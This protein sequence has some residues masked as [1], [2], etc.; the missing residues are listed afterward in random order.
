MRDLLSAEITAQAERRPDA[1]ALVLAEERLTYGELEEQSN[2]LARLLL[3]VGCGR[4]DRVCLFMP[5]GPAV[6]IALLGVLKADAIWVPLD[7]VSPAAR[8]Q[9]VIASCDCRWILAAG[10]GVGALD[11]LFADADFAAAHD[12]GWLSATG[13]Q[14]QRVQPAFTWEDLAAYSPAPRVSESGSD[15]TAHILFTSGSTGVPKGVVITHRNALQFVRWARR[16]FG[17]GPDDRVSWHPPLHFD[18]S[19]FDL[20][21]TLGAGAQLYPVPSGLSLLPHRLAEFIRGAEL[22]QWFS[23]PSVLN[24]MAKFDALREGDFPRVR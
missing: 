12:V 19:T 3:D 22:T 4:G 21:G 5:K 15:D 13:M 10:S 9:K 23:V 11:E 6:V 18:L 14:T 24:Y 2:R 7:P 17:T 20:F 16:Y 1:P 8:L